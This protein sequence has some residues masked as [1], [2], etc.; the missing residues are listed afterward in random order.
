M[1]RHPLR[2]A[3]LAIALSVTPACAAFRAADA[4]NTVAAAETADQKAYA[5]LL[6]YAAVLE[7][8]TDIVA[9]PETPPPVKT[10]LARAERIATPAADM[11]RVAFAT[12]LRARADYEAQIGADASRR[13]RA[14][15]AFVLAAQ[16]LDEAITRA[17]DPFAAFTAA[18]KQSR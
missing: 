5:L 1:R 10:A 7:E 13:E 3:L 2:A 6:G 4:V 8:A 17:R 9:D 12:Y 11:L 14:A 16:A 15:A 18:L